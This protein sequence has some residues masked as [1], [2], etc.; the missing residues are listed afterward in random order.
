[1][2]EIKAVDRLHGFQC[3]DCGAVVMRHAPD[4]PEACLC[5]S[6]SLMSTR[7][8]A[9]LDRALDS[10]KAIGSLGSWGPEVERLRKLFGTSWRKALGRAMA[11]NVTGDQLETVAK[12]FGAGWEKILDEIVA[13]TRALKTQGYHLSGGK[14]MTD[15][16]ASDPAAVAKR[17]AALLEKLDLDGESEDV[18]KLIRSAVSALRSRAAAKDDYEYPRKRHDEEEEGEEEYA[19]PT[20]KKPKRGRKVA[21][22]R[23]NPNLLD[24]LGAVTSED[25]KALREPDLR[26]NPH[27]FLQ[28]LAAASDAPFLAYESGE[29]DQDYKSAEADD[30]SPIA[31]L[32]T[33]LKGLAGGDEATAG[34]SMLERTFG[35]GGPAPAHQRRAAEDPDLVARKMYEAELLEE[36]AGRP[37][38]MT[39]AK[40]GYAVRISPDGV[41]RSLKACPR[42]SSNMFPTRLAGDTDEA[43][44]HSRRLG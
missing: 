9:D 28:S 32:R 5:G 30:L 23:R 40:C 22:G 15:Y 41:D 4:P 1:M 39:C 7:D 20:Y 26:A 29:D 21:G 27:P 24:H 36:K 8:L 19:Y 37:R 31:R 42:C 16:K 10:A 2:T 11:A 17:A 25:V 14:V 33:S 12:V 35:L 38:Y 43:R 6:K 13:N 34:H 44:S 18:K 3:L